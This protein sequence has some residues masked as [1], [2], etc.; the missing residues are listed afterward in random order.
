MSSPTSPGAD[1]FYE[2]GF[3]VR[4]VGAGQAG[5]GVLGHRAVE[6]ETRGAGRRRDQP[7]QHRDHAVPAHAL[8]VRAA[9]AHRREHASVGADQ[10]DVGLAVA[11]VDSEDGSGKAVRH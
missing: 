5:R 4:Q 10:R 9:A 11:P 7:G 3:F 2:F 8:M 6:G 1:E